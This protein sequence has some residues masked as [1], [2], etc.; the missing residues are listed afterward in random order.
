MEHWTEKEARER[1][2]LPICGMAISRTI[3]GNSK[4]CEDILRE[5]LKGENLRRSMLLV[6]KNRV[7]REMRAAVAATGNARA[8]ATL[9]CAIKR[10]EE[11]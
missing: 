7:L 1:D 9:E 2:L 11:N 6:E 3:D 5:V 8:A 10:I 4:D